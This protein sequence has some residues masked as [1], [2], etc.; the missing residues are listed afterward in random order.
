MLPSGMRRSRRSRSTAMRETCDAVA[1]GM[2]QYAASSSKRRCAEPTLVGDDP[3]GGTGQTRTHA[4]RRSR[5]R[6]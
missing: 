6:T 2:T 5:V 1:T 3:A 4:P